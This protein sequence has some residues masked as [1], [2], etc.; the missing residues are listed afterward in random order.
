[1]LLKL[2]NKRIYSKKSKN[3]INLNQSIQR[4]KKEYANKPYFQTLL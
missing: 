3:K 2:K 1:M 4:F